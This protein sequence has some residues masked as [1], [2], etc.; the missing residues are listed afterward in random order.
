MAIRER[1]SHDAPAG[2]NL[3]EAETW[4]S[5]YNEAAAQT[6][7]LLDALKRMLPLADRGFATDAANVSELPDHLQDFFAPQLAK[8]EASIQAA[9]ATVAKAEGRA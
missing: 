5:G 4:A 7:E 8:D 3:R 1:T 9:R 6:F 2:L